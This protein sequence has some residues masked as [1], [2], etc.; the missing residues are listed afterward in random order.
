MKF[1]IRLIVMLLAGIMVQMLSSCKHEGEYDHADL[2]VTYFCTK[3]LLDFFTP[4]VIITNSNGSQREITLSKN[5]FREHSDS[6]IFEFGSA[7]NTEIPTYY[8]PITERLNGLQGNFQITIEYFPL[9]DQIYDNERNYCFAD[10][11]SSYNVDIRCQNSHSIDKYNVTFTNKFPAID[12]QE[13][14]DQLLHLYAHKTILFDLT[15]NIITTD[16]DVI[17]DGQCD[18]SIGTHDHVLTIKNN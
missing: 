7:T 4:V 18:I 3:D 15:Y 11:F 1:I 6:H 8:C 17:F 10:G 14:F 5:D 13:Y 2:T 9:T 16:D 12:T